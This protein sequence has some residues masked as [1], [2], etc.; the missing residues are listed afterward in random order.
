MEREL[1]DWSVNFQDRIKKA[2][3]SH[4]LLLNEE[5]IGRIN[6]RIDTIL[7]SYGNHVNAMVRAKFLNEQKWAYETPEFNQI[8]GNCQVLFWMRGAR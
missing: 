7:L 6:Q 1:L 5:G 2:N 4:D 3:I 8:N